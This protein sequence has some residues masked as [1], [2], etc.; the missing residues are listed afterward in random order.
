[1]CEISFVRDFL[2]I[3]IGKQATSGSLCLYHDH[4]LRQKQGGEQRAGYFCS[5]HPNPSLISAS[6]LV[7]DLVP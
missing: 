4:R 2:V 1:M 5:S 6:R 7:Y 3:Y